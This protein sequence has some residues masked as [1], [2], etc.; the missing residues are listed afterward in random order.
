MR[1]GAAGDH[2][3]GQH[4]E[5]CFGGA[6]AVDQS[7]KRSRTDIGRAD[8]PKPGKPLPVAEA[9]AGGWSTHPFAPILPSVP[10]SSREMLAWCLMM[11]IRLIT[12]NRPAICGVVIK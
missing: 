3:F 7:A 5:R 9:R 4:F 10:A 11:T 2:Q 8:Q 12:A 1:I 6:E